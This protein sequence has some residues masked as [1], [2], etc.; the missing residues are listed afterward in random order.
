MI[1]ISLLALAL[2]SG[3][4]ASQTYTV[5]VEEIPFLP[6]SNVNHRKYQ[7]FFKEVMES[8]TKE[9]GVQ[10]KFR[11]L[12]LN[13]LYAQF[14]AGRLDFKL[15]ANSYWQKDIKEKNGLQIVYSD[16][17]VS[18]IDG[19]MVH[20]DDQ[21]IQIHQLKKL[22]VVSGFTPWKYL[23]DIKAGKMTIEEI[24]TIESLLNKL[25]LKRIQAIYV[26]IDVA[27]YYYHKDLA[28]HGHKVVFHK[29]LPSIKSSYH[30]ATIKHK[31]IIEKFNQFLKSPYFRKL[32]QKY[33][34]SQ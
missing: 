1:K 5:G 34:L 25:M 27:N 11:P 24:P 31:P 20:K 21:N 10:I 29:Q 6:F 33:G 28:A 2:G 9:I 7:G 26:N 8:F 16:G 17:I 19:V 15:P 14:Y 18:Y 13:R 12:P 3:T 23:D 4:A 32:Q 22:A 30:L